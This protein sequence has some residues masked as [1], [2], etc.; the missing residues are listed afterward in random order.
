[1]LIC[2]GII[3][4]AEHVLGKHIEMKKIYRTGIFGYI[5]YRLCGQQNII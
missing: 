4:F 2:I 5:T 1:M 3:E